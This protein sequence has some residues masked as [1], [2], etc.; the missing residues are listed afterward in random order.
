[1]HKRTKACHFGSETVRKIY[2]R[3]NG[4]IFCKIGYHLPEEPQSIFDVMHIV[5]RS[6]GGLG[7]E[8]N[9]VIGCR[10]HHTLLDNGNKGLREEML[11]IIE[12]YMRSKYR[13]WNRDAL[14]YRK[15]YGF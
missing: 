12:E 13:D 7:V 11:A 8:E 3:D 5:N 14:V 6:Q 10:H 4:C 9:G 1:M 2:E 15:P